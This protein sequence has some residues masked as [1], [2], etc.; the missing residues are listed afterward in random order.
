MGNFGVSELC[1][2][3]WIPE[4]PAEDEHGQAHD[5]AVAL[6]ANQFSKDCLEWENVSDEYTN[7]LLLNCF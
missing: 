1:S 6:Q 7:S 3:V 2:N 4:Q 5:V